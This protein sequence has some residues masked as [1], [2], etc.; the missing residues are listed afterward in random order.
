MKN[1]DVQAKKNPP[2]VLAVSGVKNSGKTTLI[3]ALLEIFSAQGLKVAVIKHDGHEFD[4]DVPGTDTYCQFHA[5]AYGTVVFSAERSMMVKREQGRSADDFIACFPEADLILLEG[6]KNSL[7]PKIELVRA[8]NSEKAVCD[9]AY[10]EAV[11]TNLP[12]EKFEE[13]NR[14]LFMEKQIPVL[15]LNRPENVAEFIKRRFN[16]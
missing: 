4:L 9:P 10:L 7:Y 11:V 2:A 14:A 13:E 3:C 6:F 12:A 15:L 5:G 16:L 1:T 8:G